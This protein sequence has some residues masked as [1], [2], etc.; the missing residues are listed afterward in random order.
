MQITRLVF[1]EICHRKINFSLGLITTSVVVAFT[2]ALLGILNGE[3]ANTQAKVR[4]REDEIRKITKAMGF[5][6]NIFPADL[7]L[8]RFYA[9]DF[10]DAT[11]PFEY[12]QRLANSKEIITVNHLRP[13]LIRKI[14]WS[15]Q[16]RQVILMGV[17]GVIPWTHRANPK[18]PLSQAVAPGEVVVGS[19]LAADLQLKAGDPI[20]LNSNEL[21]VSK[22]NPT[23]GN[24]DDITL[25]TDLEFAQR[26]LDQPDR[27]NMI[28]ALECNC[29]SID[30]LGEI[31]KEISNVLGDQVRVV[32]LST[33]AIA[34]AK[35]R[36]Q[37]AEQGKADL[38]RQQTL[39]AKQIL[40]CGIVGCL[41]V[42]FFAIINVR[43]RRA[44]IGI[45]R[46]IG[47]STTRIMQLFLVKAAL[48]GVVGA[49]IGSFIGVMIARNS[50]ALAFVESSHLISMLLITPCV[51][52]IASWI[53]ATLAAGQDAALILAERN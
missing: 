10:A 2:V 28:Q 18:K 42:A 32:E 5:N 27:I 9:D 48:I 29:A 23:R 11:M 49:A 3:E 13:A 43:E 46:A 45:L 37:V 22:I 34:R 26:I 47:V 19:V 15:E 33:T 4:E 51:T 36:T 17:S 40:L 25:W 20:S 44:E 21:T 7:K 14:D 53:P 24:K 30:R 39:S 50:D 38:A 1:K 52:I 6:I 8:D 41:L 31:D 12:V 16:N 35:A